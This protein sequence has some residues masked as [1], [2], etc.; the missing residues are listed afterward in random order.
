MSDDENKETDPSEPQYEPPSEKTTLAI[1]Y[2]TLFV[3]VG[4]GLLILFGLIG[5]V[6]A[7][8]MAP[9][10]IMISAC[11]WVSMKIMREALSSLQAIR[12]LRKLTADPE[13]TD[14]GPTDGP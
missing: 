13:N 7:K 2:V 10:V 1:M 8:P 9:Y 6:F 3:S 5:I 4:W 14:E 11:V 12:I